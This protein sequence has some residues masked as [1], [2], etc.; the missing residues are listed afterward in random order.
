MCVRYRVIWHTS[1]VQM[2]SG[3]EGRVDQKQEVWY[4]GASQKW[5]QKMSRRWEGKQKQ[6]GELKGFPLQ[7]STW[8]GRERNRA[9]GDWAKS[10]GVDV[11]WGSWIFGVELHYL[12]QGVFEVFWVFPGVFLCPIAFPFDQVLEFPSEHSTVQNLFHNIFLFSINEF[13]RWWWV[14]TSSSN[15]VV[16]SG[17]QFHD[18]E[19]W[20][21][22]SHEGR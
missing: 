14:L 19:D 17:R 15:Q 18:V 22:T 5:K 6:K 11:A 10:Q 12:F 1:M 20:V 4:Q 21:K 7:A 13:Q 16:G 2:E 3:S 9:E 8:C